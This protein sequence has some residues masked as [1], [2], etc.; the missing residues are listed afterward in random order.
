QLPAGGFSPDVLSATTTSML[1]DFAA[2]RVNPQKAAKAFKI[3]LELTDRKETHLITVG[4]GVLIHEE[5]VRDPK[6]GLTI[7]MKRPDL[8]MTLFAGLPY[9]SRIESGDIAAEGD[10][11][12][13][14]A[15]VGLIE[16]IVPNFPIV[17][18]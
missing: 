14:G 8:L 2:V 11:A 15:L 18:P 16:P 6:A 4:N 13:Y 9:Q 10:A 1:L 7:R 3:N 5:G 17:T 12:L